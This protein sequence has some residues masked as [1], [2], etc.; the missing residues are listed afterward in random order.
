MDNVWKPINYPMPESF[1]TKPKGIY[2]PKYFAT[3]ASIDQTFVKNPKIIPPKTEYIRDFFTN[4]RRQRN[5]FLTR[6]FDY[7]SRLLLGE[8]AHPT[9]SVGR[10]KKGRRMCRKSLRK[11]PSYEAE[12]RRKLNKINWKFF[13]TLTF[14]RNGFYYAKSP[15][16]LH[17]KLILRKDPSY[18]LP[19]DWDPYSWA[20]K[21]N[22]CH[23][24]MHS[25]CKILKVHSWKDFKF[26]YVIEPHKDGTPHIH[27]LMSTNRTHEHDYLY[28]QQIWK[29]LRGGRGRIDEIKQKSG[30]VNYVI[31]YITKSKDKTKFDFL[32]SKGIDVDQIDINVKIPEN[33]KAL[34]D[35]MLR[36]DERGSDVMNPVERTI[37]HIEKH[38][39]VWEE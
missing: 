1:Y 16:Q 14:D 4:A 19:E 30:A 28:L 34:K 5:S 12:L 21:V 27:F 35:I 17:D 6:D 13:G 26:F 22:T 20:P 8:S 33:E 10:P 24:M 39:K 3:L 36:R 18:Y 23:L 7:T 31:K 2:N 29:Y 15:M 9:R 38:R 11:I 25:V 32:T 37:K